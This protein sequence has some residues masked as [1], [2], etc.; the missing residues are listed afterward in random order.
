[1]EI[2]VPMNQKNQTTG[3]DPITQ[4]AV[5]ALPERGLEPDLL[6]G[7]VYTHNR[8][9]ANTAEVHQANANVQAVIELLIERGV[10]NRKELEE[11]AEEASERLKRDYI[12]RGMAVAMQE[13]G[14]SKYEFN[15]GAEIDCKSRI[16]LCKAAC[17]RLPFALSKQ[18]V[19]EGIVK[20]DPG[21]PYMNA[22]ESDGYCSHLDRCSGRCSV[23]EHRPIPWIWID[24]NNRVINP[25]LHESNWPT[26]LE[27]ND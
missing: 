15:S 3:S 27:T 12:E 9:N 13:F 16:A 14:T 6:R 1:L 17:C 24:F 20:W 23:Y 5:P 18:D 19:Q 2:V 7:L 11:R 4:P 10:L 22:R 8:A 21:Q 26:C 25:R